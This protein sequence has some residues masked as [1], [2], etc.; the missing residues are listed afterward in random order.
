M[1]N[2]LVNQRYEVVEKLGE[3]PLI[4]VY[5]ATDKLQNRLVC[6]KGIL[7]PF[8][9]DADFVEGFQQGMEASR[10]LKHPNIVQFEESGV[11]D[12]TPY[13]VTEF[14]RGINLSERIRRIAPFSLSVATDYACAIAEALH[15]AHRLGQMH[16]DLRPQH[17]MITSEGALKVS[18]FGVQNGIRRS[19]SAQK[20]SLKLM[21]PYHAPELSTAQP[22]SV[23]GDIYSAG[24][25]LYEMLTGTP[26]YVGSTPEAIADQHAFS[27]I[28][29]PRLV[30]PGV[31]KALEGII[32]KC[33]QKR[34]EMRYRTA[35]ELLTDLK[36]VR[37]ALRFGKPLSWSPIDIETA[38]AEIA[39][40]VPR[41]ET[42]P[43][44]RIQEPVAVVA[45]SS[46]PGIAVMPA[47]LNRLR[48]QGE[49]VSLVLKMLIGFTAMVILGCL[50]GFAAIWVKY[51]VTPVR[52]ALPVMEG[53]TIGEIEAMAKKMKITLK[54]HGSYRE[55][56]ARN[57]VYRTEPARGERI[58]AG[59]A[60]NVWF[61]KGSEWVDVPN[62][63]GLQRDDAEKK[64]KDAG[65]TVGR[66]TQEFSEKIA[67]GAV[68]AQD[69]SFKKRVQH[70]TAVGII[71]SE[72]KKPD[73][74]DPS[75][76][77]SDPLSNGD[78][79]APSD[80]SVDRNA[81][82]P[83]AEI[84][85][86]H[87]FKHTLTV[88]QDG[89]NNR[90]VRV[91]YVDADGEHTPVINEDHGEGDRI[92]LYFQYRGKKITLRVFYDDQIQGEPKEFDPEQMKKEVHF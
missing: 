78:V 24:A 52:A 49:S 64:L 74:A 22:G 92:P 66:I 88:Q 30:N 34:P 58:M 57:I 54:E 65:L 43:P 37:D 48:S 7:P 63:A 50:M 1:I 77:S 87:E 42:P 8:D 69:V 27:A 55:K 67:I 5:R 36:A 21:A 12:G 39:P 59:H 51:W 56:P 83:P 31:P 19:S 28:P 40:E 17:V 46:Q 75:V 20:E 25:I 10:V 4:I 68:V 2:Q 11:S 82:N 15:H 70:D 89:K 86:M 62:V 81:E 91:E 84:Q 26:L 32:L 13:A 60:L 44:S 41:I 23:G 85:K 35:A 16:G 29:L 45:A 80:N 61:S 90:R 3:S 6:V 53:R 33:L 9:A 76:T 72:G 73:Y 18:D 79:V 14:V 47:R 71:I 38:S